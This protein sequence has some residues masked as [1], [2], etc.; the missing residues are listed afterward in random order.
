[1]CANSGAS[2]SEATP[3]RKQAL[4][5][6]ANRATLG[7]RRPGATDKLITQDLTLRIAQQA[8]PRRFTSRYRPRH[9]RMHSVSMPTAA[10]MES[11]SQC[12][13]KEG[14]PRTA[15]LLNNTLALCH[16]RNMPAFSFSSDIPPWASTPH[17]F[18]A[19]Q[20]SLLHNFPPSAHRPAVQPKAR[21]VDLSTNGST[22]GRP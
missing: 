5:R 15:Q 6:D 8:M 17:K 1:M 18:H 4:P 10:A 19:H 20:A 13:P 3:G 14:A 22:P 9:W 11:A 12:P 16:A 7:L 2:L 21:L